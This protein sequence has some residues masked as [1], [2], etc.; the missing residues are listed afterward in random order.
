[1]QYDDAY[2]K[3]IVAAQG[4]TDVA[5]RLADELRG[6]ITSLQAERDADQA[7]YSTSQA[8][9]DGLLSRIEALDSLTAVR[10]ALATAHFFLFL[11]FM[12]LEL[13]PVIVKMLQLMGPPSAYEQMVQ[14]LEDD[15]M[16]QS[17]L[18]IARE[19][20]LVE[21][22]GERMLD[23]QLDWADRQYEAG[24]RSNEEVITRQQAIVARA[25]DEWADRA[26]ADSADRTSRFAVGGGSRHP[27]PDTG[28][29]AAFDPPTWPV[30]ASRR[31]GN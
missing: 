25:I 24:L 20:E 15:A 7:T 8:V 14:E 6:R 12:T 29:D 11:L 9:G 21:R 2:S 22:E 16:N 30:P 13:L 18:R 3:A 17:A 1:L 19:R 4:E 28:A 26:T 23:L 31:R 27:G 5:K 10:P